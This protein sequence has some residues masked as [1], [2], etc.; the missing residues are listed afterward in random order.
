[1]LES[2]TPLDNISS[3]AIQKILFKD[4]GFELAIATNDIKSFCMGYYGRGG[5]SFMPV[6]R[7]K[8]SSGKES[9]S[10]TGGGSEEE[11]SGSGGGGGESG[12]A[13]SGK[14]KSLYEGSS[15]ALFLHGKKVGE[16]TKEQTLVFN[17]LRK[18]FKDSTIT[19]NDVTTSDGQTGNY[20]LNSLR[21]SPKTRL[22][23]NDEGVTLHL[24]IDM[25]CRISDQSTQKSDD[26]YKNVPL[27]PELKAKAEEQLKTAIEELVDAE[28]SSGCDFLELKDKL[29]RFNNRYYEKYK[30]SLLDEMKVSVTVSINAQ[31]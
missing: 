11:L 2:S 21:C 29:Y 18:D 14:G 9:S 10:G 6:M 27:P 15:T 24:S 30:N 3:F 28:I 19:V 22:V 31:R 26:I 17:A 7:I 8:D 13:T 12:A 23:V 5:S 1:M 16:L 4:V 20:L 25:R